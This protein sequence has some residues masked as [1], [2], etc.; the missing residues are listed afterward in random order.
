MYI[1]FKIASKGKTKE[2]VNDPVTLGDMLSHEQMF[3]S[4]LKM[5]PEVKIV[6]EERSD[7]IPDAGDIKPIDLENAEISSKLG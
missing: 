2:G 6:S 7:K 1:F 4:L 3:Y 5:F